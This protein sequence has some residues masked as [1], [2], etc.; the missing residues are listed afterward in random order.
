MSR[1]HSI[2]SMAIKKSKKTEDTPADVLALYKNIENSELT[3]TERTLHNLADSVANYEAETMRLKEELERTKAKVD[4]LKEK[5]TNEDA[6]TEK[7]MSQLRKHV[8]FESVKAGKDGG[9]DY[10]EITTKLLF[11][12]IRTGEGARK[13]ER[14]CIGAYALKMWPHSI[15]HCSAKNL[16]FAGRD[17]WATANSTVCLG[18][19]D[20][21]Y[22]NAVAKGDFYTAFEAICMLL[23]DASLDGSAYTRSHMWRDKRMFHAIGKEATA[24]KGDY[25]MAVEPEYDGLYVLGCVGIYAA[26]ERDSGLCRVTFKNAG[27]RTNWDWWLPNTM[28]VKIPPEMHSA[29]PV[30]KIDGQKTLEATAKAMAELDAAPEGTTQEYLEVLS[31][32]YGTKAVVKLDLAE[33]MTQVSPVAAKVGPTVLS[34]N[35][36]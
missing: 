5:P 21:D 31:D 2:K 12:D 30:Y 26:D 14:A 10:I 20:H 28:L 25:V 16:T 1:R 23:K 4:A 9:H 7:L 17:H 36:S 8:A 27:G 33:L 19:W 32:K 29:A 24:K 3:R 13:T 15:G 18:D 11:A 34:V 22:R 6:R 35:T